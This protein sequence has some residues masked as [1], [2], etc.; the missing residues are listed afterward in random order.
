MLFQRSRILIRKV[1]WPQL[2]ENQEKAQAEEAGILNE[3]LQTVGTG[4][5]GADATATGPVAG[6]DPVLISLIR[7]SMPGLIAYMT[8]LVFECTGQLHGPI[9]AMRT[10]YGTMRDATDSDYREAFFNELSTLDS[11]VVLVTVLQ[12]Y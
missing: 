10:N 11:L 9:F 6:F 8:L 4:G 7:R 12:D 1:L 2:L 3:T 5:Y